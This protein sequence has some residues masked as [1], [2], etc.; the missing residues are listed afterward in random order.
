M[1][2]PNKLLLA[3]F[4]GARTVAR[5]TVFMSEKKIEYFEKFR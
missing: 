4:L 1:T 5:D 2:T 3:V